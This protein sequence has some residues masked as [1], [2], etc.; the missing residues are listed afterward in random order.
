MYYKISDQQELVWSYDGVGADAAQHA[1]VAPIAFYKATNYETD[2][3]ALSDTAAVNKMKSNIDYPGEAWPCELSRTKIKD[4]KTFTQHGDVLWGAYPQDSGTYEFQDGNL[5]CE[6]DYTVKILAAEFGRPFNKAICMLIENYEQNLDV[7]KHRHTNMEWSCQDGDLFPTLSEKCNGERTC[8][9]SPTWQ[10]QHGQL[11][12]F[13]KL[14][15]SKIPLNPVTY[16]NSA[17]PFAENVSKRTKSEMRSAYDYCNRLQKCWYQEPPWY[18]SGC[19]DWACH[20]NGLYVSKYS[21]VRYLCVSQ[22]KGHQTRF[23]RLTDS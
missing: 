13:A 3:Y 22:G 2:F 5:Q 21:W 23:D 11:A 10:S 8:M 18:C 4:D 16:D 14:H 19:D 1:K 7:L 20:D 6:G 15:D 12:D 9:I 17:L